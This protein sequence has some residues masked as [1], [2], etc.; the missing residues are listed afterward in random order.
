V[1]SLAD[2]ELAAWV[3][4]N[5]SG[6]AT[7][8]VV[9]VRAAG[10]A[11]ALARAR[12]PRLRRVSDLAIDGPGGTLPLRLYEPDGDGG[13]VIVFFHGGMWML[14]DLETHDRTCR[15]LADATGVRVLAVDF[16][17]APEHRWPA[18]VDDCEAAVRWAGAE[19][20]A[21]APVLAGDSAGGHL[22]LLV[23]LRGVPAG[24]LLLA[25]PNTDLRLS[26]PSVRE[27]GE[28]WGL[29]ADSLRWA[30]DQWLPPDTPRDD[31]AVSPLLADLAG[32]P[33]TL[34]VTA[35]HD[36]LRDEGDA[37]ARALAQAGVRVVHRCERGMVHGFIQNLDLV[38]PAAGRAAA[39]WLDDARELVR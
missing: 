24:G 10:R 37:L 32:L 6:P 18:A 4:E 28:G 12:E 17:R 25:C 16:R 21:P 26:T 7:F 39:R 5:G 9:Q 19:L 14:G 33:A 35:S 36:P 11:R 13:Q 38:S 27:L 2:P 1:T 30:V 8:D 15:R 20:G 3:R 34:V 29:S 22:A 23:A 31:P